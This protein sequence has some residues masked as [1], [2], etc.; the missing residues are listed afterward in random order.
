[1]SW[2]LYHSAKFS[3]WSEGVDSFSTTAALKV[4]PIAA[5]VI[6]SVTIPI[7]TYRV[8]CVY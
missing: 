1:M 4:D 7:A 3:D 8:T 2:M 6:L 5:R